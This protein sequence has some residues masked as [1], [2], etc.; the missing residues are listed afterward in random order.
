MIL[1]L[2]M[3]AIIV[4]NITVLQHFPGTFL[5][6]FVIVFILTVN[7]T[8]YITRISSIALASFNIKSIFADFS[9]S[10]Q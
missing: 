1:Y 2:L 9:V 10:A 8:F 4:K 5:Y 7:L 3:K 6:L